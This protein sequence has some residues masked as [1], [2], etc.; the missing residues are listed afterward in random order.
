MSS[1]INARTPMGRAGRDGELDSAIVFLAADESSYVT[2][3][4]CYVDGGWTCI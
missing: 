4:I 3:L 1:F 2:G